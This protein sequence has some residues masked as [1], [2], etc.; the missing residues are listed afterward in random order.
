[1][2]QTRFVFAAIPVNVN[3]VTFAL[4]CIQD[5]LPG[6]APENWEVS[7]HFVPAPP[8]MTVVPV[9][10]VKP[11]ATAETFETI[12]PVQITQALQ[13]GDEY[14]V[15]GKVPDRYN[16]VT[17]ANGWV[18]LTDSRLT[19]AKGEEVYAQKPSVEGL[20][21]YDWGVQF[22]AGTVQ[23]PVTFAFDWVRIAPLPDFSC[24]IRVRHRGES[25]A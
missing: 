16:G 14:I 12:A 15:V 1:M 19:D 25:P 3:D 5:T 7:L 24:R 9:I 23:F 21:D 18:E 11:S 6:K 4:P 2:R 8:D 17:L 13:V 20:H 22:K 10:E